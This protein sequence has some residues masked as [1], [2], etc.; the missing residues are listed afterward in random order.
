MLKGYM[1]KER[2]G[3]PALEDKHTIIKCLLNNIVTLNWLVYLKKYLVK[4]ETLE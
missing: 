4:P 2:L 3:T 1:V